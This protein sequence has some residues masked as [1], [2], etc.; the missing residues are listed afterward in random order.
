MMRKKKM[1]NESRSKHKLYLIGTGALGIAVILLVVATVRGHVENTREKKS[2][3]DKQK[4]GV[5]T[6]TALVTNSPP[7]H[8]V[9]LIGE[10]RPYFTTSLFG[11]VSGYLTHVLV[12]KGDRV[13]M[14][15]VLATIEAP[16]VDKSYLSALADAKNRKQIADRYRIL[17]RRKLISQQDFEQTAANSEIATATLEIQKT[18]KGYQTVRAPFDGTITARFA[19]PGT[20]VQSASGSQAGAQALFMVSQT[21]RLRVYVYVDQK[22]SAHVHPGILAEISSAGANSSSVVRVSRVAGELDQKT[23]TL[24]TE[25]DIDNTDRKIV[26]G[27]FVQVKLKVPSPSF[28]E[29]PTKALIVRENKNYV[30]IVR[31]DHTV[32]YQEVH[33]GENDGFSLQIL[34]GVE[35]GQVVALD[36]GALSEG[37][38]IQPV[39]SGSTGHEQAGRAA[40]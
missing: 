15:Q 23:R 18:L 35:A 17:R 28:L 25:I 38:K 7:F 39:T 32:K 33:I 2:L 1:P 24:L 14:G 13:E 16:E 19:D 36:A 12:D 29:V 40:K 5:P 10:A 21:D 20:L 31:P 26:A 22:N 8:E 37:Q 27:S 34:S 6:A 3:E 11:R 9:D 4:Q 30:S